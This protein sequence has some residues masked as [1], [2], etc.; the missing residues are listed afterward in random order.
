MKS[1]ICNA[2]TG[3]HV[4]LYI[5]PAAKKSEVV[6]FHGEDRLKIKIK[7]PPED[8]QANQELIRFLAEVL[9]LQKAHVEILRGH[10]SRKKDVL[11]LGKTVSFVQLK[12]T[13][14]KS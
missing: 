13:P 11:F 5:Q 12:L 7:A 9:D 14:K 6:G 3:C 8:G 4:Y 2:P 10:K 1:W